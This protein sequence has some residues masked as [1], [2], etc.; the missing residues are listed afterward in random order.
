MHTHKYM[1]IHTHTNKIFLN[2][3]NI[4]PKKKSNIVVFIG[5]KHVSFNILIQMNSE[6]NPC[7]LEEILGKRNKEQGI[8]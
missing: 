6:V 7:I 3:R 2:Y 5:F 8:P 1:Y 4:K